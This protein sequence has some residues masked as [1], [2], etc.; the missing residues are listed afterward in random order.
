M[1][2]EEIAWLLAD[3][4]EKTSEGKGERIAVVPLGW[5]CPNCGRGNAPATPY[6]CTQPK[7]DVVRK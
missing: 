4:E 3:V 5:R 2:D 6:C 1:T 7:P